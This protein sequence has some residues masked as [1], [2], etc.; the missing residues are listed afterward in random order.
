[1]KFENLRFWD[2]KEK[3]MIYPEGIFDEFFSG[4]AWMSDL[5]RFWDEIVNAERFKSMEGVEAKD[6]NG[7][8][9][10]IYDLVKLTG[11]QDGIELGGTKYDLTKQIFCIQ[12]RFSE[13]GRVLLKF[14]GGDIIYDIKTPKIEKIG[15]LIEN[16]EMFTKQFL[17]EEERMKKIPNKIKTKKAGGNVKGNKKSK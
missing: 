11:Y 3:K 8:D 15:T 12:K 1:M 6:K 10:Y 2:E 7:D 16:E 4:G 5:V 13:A 14:Y 17:D 9:L